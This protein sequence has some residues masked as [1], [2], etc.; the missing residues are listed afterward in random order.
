MTIMDRQY[1]RSSRSRNRGS[2]S[3][4]TDGRARWLRPSGVVEGWKSTEE[5]DSDGSGGTLPVAGGRVAAR[6]DANQLQTTPTTLW[7]LALLGA[8]SA[9]EPRPISQGPAPTRDAGPRLPLDHA[10]AYEGDEP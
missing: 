2:V 9:Q 5:A 3:R 1:R 10:L 7:S 8:P 6:R 4:N